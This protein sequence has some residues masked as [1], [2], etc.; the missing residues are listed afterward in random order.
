MTHQRAYSRDVR[1]SSSALTGPAISRPDT[2][3][4]EL[5]A[6]YREE[7]IPAAVEFLLQHR[8]RQRSFLLPS[9]DPRRTS[10]RFRATRLPLSEGR[11]PHWTLSSPWLCIPALR[12]VATDRWDGCGGTRRASAAPRDSGRPGSCRPE[13]RGCHPGTPSRPRRADRNGPG[14]ERWR[15]SRIEIS[16]R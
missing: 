4:R 11:W 12:F 7:R 5:L 9:A 8:P 3:A 16:R 6:L 1:A 2:L 14:A 15:R 13:I 10:R